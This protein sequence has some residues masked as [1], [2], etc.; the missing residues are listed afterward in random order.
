MGADGLDVGVDG[1]VDGRQEALVDRHSGDGRPGEAA[2]AAAAAAKSTVCT[3]TAESTA[4]RGVAGA[5]GHATVR[6]TTATTAAPVAP[7]LG[8][9]T[10]ARDCRGG[11]G[12]EGGSLLEGHGCSREG[13]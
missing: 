7:G 8:H 3:A 4:H 6:A 11:L 10:P 12:G 13:C 2:A 1:H 9:G 5:L